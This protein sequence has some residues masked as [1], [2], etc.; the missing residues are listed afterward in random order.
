MGSGCNKCCGKIQDWCRDSCGCC[1]C[2]CCKTAKIEVKAKETIE[3][4]IEKKETPF[5]Y[6]LIHAGKQI[7]HESI[8]CLLYLICDENP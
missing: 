6:G 8:T 7:A 3:Y 5:G 1:P 4:K 2:K